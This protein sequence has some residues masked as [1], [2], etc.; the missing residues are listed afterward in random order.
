MTIAN[1][2][3]KFTDYMEIGGGAYSEVAGVWLQNN[4]NKMGKE[5]VDEI[6]S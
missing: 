5:M 2:M 3:N 6:K 4:V 1:V